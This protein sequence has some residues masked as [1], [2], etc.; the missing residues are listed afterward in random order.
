M[1]CGVQYC[2]SQYP[3]SVGQTKCVHSGL[4]V[5]LV[6][7]LSSVA[8]SSTTRTLTCFNIRLLCVQLGASMGHAP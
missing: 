4:T 3:W 2:L 6:Q 5:Q 7:G 8:K 1:S